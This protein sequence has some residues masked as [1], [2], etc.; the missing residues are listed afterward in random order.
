MAL[1][2]TVILTLAIIVGLPIAVAV[3][4]VSTLAISQHAFLPISLLAQRVYVGI[5]S[6]PLIAVPLFILAGALMDVGGISVRITQLAQSFVG[7][8]RGGL[9][10]VTVCGAMIFGLGWTNWLRLI[11]WLMIGLVFY[12]SYGIRH[13]KVQALETGGK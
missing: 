2:V 11:V 6:F 13:S 12:F 7:H 1:A 9:G 8:L 5:D 3:G 4:A 10:M